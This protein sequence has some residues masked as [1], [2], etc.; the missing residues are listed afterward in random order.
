MNNGADA[1]HHARNKPPITVEYRDIDSLIP[2][3]NNARTHNNEQ[4]SQIAASIKEF[5]WTQ[6]V[7]VDGNNGIIA[8]H[9]RVQ[10]AYKLKMIDIPVI[11]LHGLSDAQKRAYI[12]AD[13]RLAQNAGWDPDLLHLELTEL[14]N[15]DFDLSLLGF[16]P[17]EL[18]DLLAREPEEGLTDPDEVP[19]APAKALT[20]LGDLWMLGEHRLLCGDSTDAESVAYLMDG[21]KADMVF[22]DP[23]YNVDYSSKQELLN[24]Y[25]NGNILVQPLDGDH[26][27]EKEYAKFCNKVYSAFEAVLSDYNAIYICGN[28]ESLIPFYKLGKLK[29]SNMLVWVKSSLVMGRMD[30]QNQHEF[31]LYGWVGRHKWHSDR[32]QTTVWEYAKPSKSELHPTMKPVELVENAVANSTKPQQIVYDSFLGSGTTL[33]A[34][35]QLGRKCYGLEITPIYC[36]VIIKRWEAFTGKKATLSGY[37]GTIEQLQ[38]EREHANTST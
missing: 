14:G 13:N 27:D 2:Y 1:P 12:L 22:T 33:I 6:P 5:G 17:G 7:L 26:I 29:I 8:G 32:K 23:P 10:A 11:E 20:Q 36:D 18:S 35:E 30:Y 21:A 38:R 9:G 3:I 15:A 19:D 31:I 34:A 37:D 4:V 24:L 16:E 25:D 28:Y